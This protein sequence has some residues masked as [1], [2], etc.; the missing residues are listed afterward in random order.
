VLDFGARG[1]GHTDDT[2][3]IRSAVKAAF[4]RRRIPL[5]PQY[6]YFVSLAEVYFPSG[7]YLISD[8]IDINAVKLRGENYAAVEQT[9]PEKDIFFTPWAWRQTIE[10]LTLLGG[11]VHLNL[12]NNN[13]GSGHVT[14]RD[15]HFYNS[16]D[17]AVQMR[18]G[19]NS[20]FFKVENCV[21][22]NCEQA[23]INHCDMC[24]IRDCWIS[25]SKEMKDKAV[26]VNRGVMHLEDVLG[27]PRVNG[28]DQRWIDNHA[29]LR[30]TRFRFG[31]EGAG[32][33]PV[34]N[35]AKP[36]KWPSSVTLDQCYV[37]SLGNPERKCAVYLEEIPNTVRIT[38][39]TGFMGQTELIQLSSEIDLKAFRET[40]E[41]SPGYFH[42][43][44]RGNAYPGGELP[45]EFL[46]Y[47]NLSPHR[48][49]DERE[50][51]KGKNE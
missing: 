34:V 20:S 6:G 39:C 27:V 51:L 8:T 29:V 28:S 50:T 45:K 15:C 14:V 11:K 23:V 37:Y 36:Y 22:I 5:H 18:A 47:T 4:E 19:S 24:V 10:G 48:D 38:D 13:I 33:T 26:I 25:T 35:F 12:G 44:I 21:F 41:T 3:A 43:T 40:A 31:G 2:E 49:M 30:V 46:P 42:F 32:F 9:N 16:S 17:V 1:D 7:H